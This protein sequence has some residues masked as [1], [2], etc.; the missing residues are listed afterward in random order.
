LQLK[1][2][3]SVPKGVDPM[4]PQRVSRRAMRGR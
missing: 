4:H 1:N 3:M 2:G